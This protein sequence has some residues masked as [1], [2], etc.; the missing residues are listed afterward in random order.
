MGEIIVRKVRGMNWKAKIALVLM[1]TLV[2]STFM[3]QGLW[4]PAKSEAAAVVY[5]VRGLTAV[6]VGV[7]G[8]TNIVSEAAI[9]TTNAAGGTNEWRAITNTTTPPGTSRNRIRVGAAWTATGDE[10]FRAYTPVY[11]SAT[12]IAANAT[13]LLT[14]Y[15]NTTGTSGSIYASMY[16]YNDTTGIVGAVKG[17]TN[18]STLGATATA[19]TVTF[20]NPSF[21]VA[22]G[23]RVLVIFYATANGTDPAYLFGA[24]ALNTT[25]P[26]GDT[27]FT[28]NETAVA[29][30]A[31]N[32]ADG[33][34]PA[35]YNV[36]R[37]STNNVADSFTMVSTNTDNGAAAVTG[38]TASFTNSA[39]IS[40][41]RLYK[42]VNANGTYQAGTDTLL[43]TGTPGASV[44]FTGFTE[45]LTTT[46][47]NYLILV[48][49]SGTAT[50]TQTIDTVV[51][52]V[53]VTA[54]DAQGTISD[55][56]NP[57]RLTIVDVPHENVGTATNTAIAT[58]P[59]TESAM[60]V[61]M[62]RFQ[63]TSA[64][65][66]AGAQDNQ[67]ELN[68][69]GID[70]LG[71][72]T[73]ARTAKV[74][75]DSTS[76]ATLP[77]TAVLIG[78]TSGWTGT[79]TTITLNQGTAGDRTVTNATARYIYIVYDMPA[80]ATQTVQSSVTSL[81]VV[82]PDAGQTGLTLNSTAITLSSD[83]SKITSCSGC[84]G[85][86]GAFSDGT[87][88][89]TPAGLFQGSHNTHVQ[90]Y[91]NACSVCHTVPATETSADFK[92]RDGTINIAGTLDVG[93]SNAGS[94]SK[95]SFTQA[96]S[97]AP[98]N[99]SNTYC[100]SNGT[101]VITSTIP[102]NTS[103]NWGGATTCSSCHGNPADDGRPNYANGTP[104]RNTHGDGAGYGNTHKATA[105]PTC[106]TGVSGTAG[107]YTISDTGTHNNGA[108]NL[109]ASMGYTQATGVCATASCHGGSVTWGGSLACID[110][111]SSPQGT[112]ADVV[113]EFGLAW[114][115]KKSGR[116][117][118]SDADCIVCHLEGKYSAGV[119]S[120]VIKTAFHSGAPGG[121]IDLRDPDGAGETPITNNSGAAF[122][123]SQY[124]VSYA[125]GSRTT[126]LGNTVAEVI[127]VKFCMKCHDANGA[128]NPTARSNNGGTG[129]ATMPFGGVNLGA[130]YTTTNGAA[131]A[132]GLIDVAKQFAS[133]NSS[134][135]P[136]G[137]PN[138]RAYPYSTRL[139]APYNGL[140]TARDGNLTTGTAATPRTK[141]NSVILVCDDCHTTST[142][143]TT[144]TITAH[145][146]ASAGMRGGTY[147]VSG[148]TLC[149]T[150]HI[151]TYADTT[152]GR[153][154]SGS[155]FAVG[156]TRAAA[157]LNLCNFCHFSQNET[158][159][160]ARPRI[161][162]DV[163]GFNELYGTSAGW[164][165]G[166]ASGMRPVA[167]MRSWATSGGSWPTTA[168]P[169]PFTATVAGPG[170]FNL[171]AGQP[172]C[173]GTFA[174][175]TT[176]TTM[177]CS[178]NGHTNYSPGGSY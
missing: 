112:R 165:A 40:G 84:H 31:V 36:S 152:N 18:S 170:Q 138:N 172:Q 87:A 123:F 131:A 171:A 140:G 94:Y 127:T 91:G 53:T 114:G 48:D 41:V 99:C 3:Y 92:H 17:T 144:R 102:A 64:T 130:N 8:N 9:T 26:A 153:H 23:N 132:G 34:D 14:G 129:T 37:G 169:R 61:L 157:A 150:C 111:H 139:L 28:L 124:S 100:H 4:K 73:G 44:S 147:F 110:C 156:T 97:F 78:S 136:V 160:I 176:G 167:F 158:T 2:F 128:T 12:N 104:K 81:G 134:R 47:S 72:A 159:G 162:Q 21:N 52:A 119:G 98:G 146:A 35:N 116:T 103:P 67:V 42:D 161:A 135:H 5:H 11:A 164:T 133:T 96:N 155:A 13:A 15:L 173:G 60:N 148:P 108:Y 125:A 69:L 80:G 22:A 117:A 90:Q 30:D 137:A 75:I 118:V 24:N 27:Y 88:R 101:S 19:T 39:N 65:S 107:A 82:S 45:N 142:A 77:G 113:A 25:T 54:P 121:N 32:V 63:V 70:D 141:A 175:N 57:T 83:P 149:T 109:Q 49:I 115:H 86:T 154:N 68:S 145:G 74:Y 79:P 177:S 29:G 168:S 174:F 106:H 33:T 143:L 89:N 163:H 66:G 6:S 126:T 166:S 178:S 120:A 20:T 95:T 46:A 38:V 76:S 10:R 43:S 55:A 59:K 85:Y 71:T 7:D 56:S 58:S 122:T 62:Q 16:E 50:L 105:C 151:G 1:F 51:T 93:G